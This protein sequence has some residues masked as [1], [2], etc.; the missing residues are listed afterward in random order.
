MESIIEK[1]KQMELSK[2]EVQIANYILQEID[3]VGMM[4]S[5][6]LAQAIGVSDTS[7]IRF[8]RRLGFAKYGDFR[9]Q[10]NEQLTQRYEA[11]QNLQTPSAKYQLTK[12]R[13]RQKDLIGRVSN[14]VLNN[15][16]NSLL[17]IT[18][19]LLQQVTQ[20][21]LKNQHIYVAGF[22][23]TV[24]CVTYLCSK[25]DLLLPHVIPVTHADSSAL[26]TMVDIGKRDCLFLIS[27]SRYSKMAEKIIKI[28]H[29]N[30]AKII[31]LTDYET[32]PFARYA[33]ILLTAKVEGMGFTNS[34][35]APFCIIELIILALT[36]ANVP[37][38]E[39]RLDQLDTLVVKEKLY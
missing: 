30:H 14:W 6:S 11:K 8:I 23:G 21:L 29:E 2:V 37:A 3:T 26:E 28:A 22:R 24:S 33:D 1:I 16:E 9:K 17:K 5:S 31:L 19:E 27:F 39:K 7:V 13:L 25:L 4:T 32:A 35:I 38:I 10:M 12:E 36:S 18:P 34:Y 15:L 20:V